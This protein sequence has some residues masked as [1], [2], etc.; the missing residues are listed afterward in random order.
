[1]KIGA[2]KALAQYTACQGWNMRLKLSQDN[3]KLDTVV[4]FCDKTWFCKLFCFDSVKLCIFQISDRLNVLVEW[5]YSVLT[6]QIFL[7]VDPAITNIIILIQTFHN[8]VRLRLPVPAQFGLTEPMGSPKTPKLIL[9]GQ[10]RAKY[11]PQRTEHS[12]T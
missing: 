3:R 2:R 9:L 10:D 11:H 4:L 8:F 7:N 6:E 12:R 1:M 5:S